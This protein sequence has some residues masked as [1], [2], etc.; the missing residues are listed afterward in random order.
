MKTKIR[1]ISIATSLTILFFSVLLLPSFSSARDVDFSWTANPEPVTG[2]KLY[3]KT[4]LNSGPPYDGTGLPEGNSPISV[5]NVTAFTVTNLS[6]SQTYHFALQA[7][8]GDN[9]SGLTAPISYQPI[10]MGS[11]TI[12]IMSQVN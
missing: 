2:Y 7:V 10:A 9:E 4:G 11:P 12:E 8:V 3:Y 6:P 5:G 1:F